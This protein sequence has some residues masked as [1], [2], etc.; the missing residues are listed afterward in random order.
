M[1][2]KRKR[3]HEEEKMEKHLLMTKVKLANTEDKLSETVDKLAANETK[4]HSTETRLGSLEVMMHRLI[5]TTE[6]SNTLIGSA[7]WPSHLTKLAT[8][9]IGV[10]QIYPVIVKMS[11][12]VEHK[13]IHVAWLGEPFYSQTR[14]YKMSLQIYAAG[15]GDVK[16]T[17]LSAFLN[18][19]KGP[20]DDELTWPLMGKFEIMLLN[21]KCN[22][23][24]YS[25]SVIYNN[26][27][28][29][30]CADRVTGCN[31]AASGWGFPKFVSNEDLQKVTPTC[32]Y[33]KDNCIFLRISKL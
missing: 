33:L 6:S 13:R 32:Q 23:E 12:F 27:T 28:T 20:H 9:V 11:N 19:M 29:H 2:R 18:L 7:Q 24:H 8:K 30:K 1:L 22:S 25:R 10:T 31:R 15:T 5:N 3:E 17:Y 21:Q 4:L 26:H 14:G 16:D